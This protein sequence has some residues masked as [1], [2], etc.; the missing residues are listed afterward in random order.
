MSIFYLPLVN[1]RE[2]GKLLLDRLEHNWRETE[3]CGVPRVGSRVCLHSHPK[4]TLRRHRNSR[5]YGAGELRFAHAQEVLWK[6]SAVWARALKKFR[7]PCTWPQKKVQRI[8]VL[9]APNIKLPG[10]L[11]WLGP[12]LVVPKFSLDLFRRR[13][14]CDSKSSLLCARKSVNNLPCISLLL[15]VL[16]NSILRQILSD[17]SFFGVLQLI[18]LICST[19]ILYVTPISHFFRVRWRQ[20]SRYCLIYSVFQKEWPDFK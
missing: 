19:G 10:A 11:T 20:L 7:H 17:A 12:A 1:S 16:R 15:F 8:S 14:I 13:K 18:V 5:K 9:R 4:G 6:L 3:D 2:K